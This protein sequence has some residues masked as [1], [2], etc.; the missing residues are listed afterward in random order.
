MVLLAAIIAAIASPSGAQTTIPFTYVDNR[1]VVECKINGKGPFAMILDTGSP[2]IAL[3]PA[4]AAR[5]TEAG[6]A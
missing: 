6:F 5:L 2:T 3:T 4:T 1:I